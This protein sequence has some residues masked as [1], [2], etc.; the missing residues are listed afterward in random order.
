M[1]T[2]VCMYVVYVC[3][4]FSVFTYLWAHSLVSLSCYCENRY[5]KHGCASDSEVGYRPLWMYA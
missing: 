4:F 5:D 1:A 3:K 2:H